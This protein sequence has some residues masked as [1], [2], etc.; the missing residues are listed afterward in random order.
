MRSIPAEQLLRAASNNPLAMTGQIADGY[1]L[2]EDVYSIFAKG[3]QQDVPII[4]GSNANEGRTLRFPPP[5][6]AD[7]ELQQQ[8]DKQYPN[9]RRDEVMG[10]IMLWTAHTWAR[11]ET[12]TGT[13]K[14]YQYYFSHA[15][16]FPAD[17]KFEFDVSRLGA[18]H[19]AEIIYVFDNL[20]IRKAR[21]WPWAAQDYKLADLMS[22]YWVNFASKGDPNGPGL[23][24]WPAYSDREPQVLNIGDAVRAE[25]L[26]RADEIRLWDRISLPRQ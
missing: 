6:V 9:D 16:P 11:L 14:A 25:P 8:L 22:S 2:P 23:P 4:V 7:A 3:K 12:K 26:P 5:K 1:V 17:Q 20:D 10:A 15:P 13:Q 24:E 21:N 18:F 19:S